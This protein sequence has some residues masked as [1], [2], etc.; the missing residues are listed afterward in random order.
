MH[1]V[2]FFLLPSLVLYCKVRI[3]FKAFSNLV[4]HQVVEDIPNELVEE[5]PRSFW[6]NL[7]AAKNWMSNPGSFWDEQ[8]ND[9]ALH[10]VS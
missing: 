7:L 8:A 6:D 5:A 10:E 3:T 2:H 1:L 9:D 4:V